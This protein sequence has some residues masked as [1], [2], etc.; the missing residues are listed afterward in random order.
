LT[1]PGHVV[2]TGLLGGVAAG[3]SRVAALLEQ[4]GAVRIDADGIAHDVLREP[5]VVAAV[6]ERFGEAVR[7]PR[8]GIDR[9]ALGEIVFGDREALARLEAIVHPRVRREIGRRLAAAPEGSIVV[10]D[11]ALLL[12]NGLDRICDVVVFVETSDAVRAQ[13]AG[14]DRG[15]DEDETGRRE[16]HQL[17]VETKRDRADWIVRNDGSPEDLRREVG[18][19]WSR[20][21]TWLPRRER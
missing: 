18:K 6:I 11:A 4:R 21:E 20:L 16:R 7:S 19:L 9:R 12:E 3:K 1:H 15:W 2:V 8:D 17:P 14:R 13:R 10:L 5:D